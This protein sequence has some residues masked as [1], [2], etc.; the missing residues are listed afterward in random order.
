MLAIKFT[1]VKIVVFHV[2]TS[3]RWN[4]RAHERCCNGRV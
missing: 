4:F 2:A 1:S 3:S